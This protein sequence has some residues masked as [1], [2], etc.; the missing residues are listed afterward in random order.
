MVVKLSLL[1][2]WV[3]GKVINGQKKRSSE[4]FFLPKIVTFFRLSVTLMGSV[5]LCA[6]S[7]KVGQTA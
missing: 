3:I 7:G 4:R 5:K 2:F 1:V 6:L